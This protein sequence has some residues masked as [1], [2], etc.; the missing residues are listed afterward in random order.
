M[1]TLSQK[2]VLETITY[3][4]ERANELDTPNNWQSLMDNLSGMKT[5]AIY[6]GSSKAAKDTLDNLWSLALGRWSMAYHA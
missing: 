2:M 1:K 6:M 5:L 4:W 3:R